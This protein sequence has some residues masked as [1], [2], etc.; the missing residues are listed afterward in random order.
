MEKKEGSRDLLGTKGY[1]FVVGL[2]FLQSIGRLLF[3]LMG[4]NGGIDQFLDVPV[5]ITTA[6]ALHVMFFFLGIM[7]FVAAIGFWRKKMWGFWA[8]LLV[9]V[10]TI[11]FDIWGFTIQ[12]TAA[13]GFIVPIIS[14]VYLISQRSHITIA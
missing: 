4:L 14:L 3:A 11:A 6:Q 5:S 10:M 8:I 1:A 12:E 9:S 7:G 2:N 13:L